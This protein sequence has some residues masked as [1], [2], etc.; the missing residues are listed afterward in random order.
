MFSPLRSPRKVQRQENIISY[1]PPNKVNS[2]MLPSDHPFAGNKLNGHNTNRENARS[3]PRKPVD[4]YEDEVKRPSMHKKTKSSVSLKSLIGNDKSKNERQ[5]DQGAEDRPSL[6]KTKSSTGL[7]AL[8]SRPKALKTGKSEAKSPAKDKENQTPPDA[9]DVSPPP[10]WAQYSTQLP[11]EQR[12][13]TKIPLNDQSGLDTVVST[14]RPQDCS[15]SGEGNFQGDR[16]AWS[17]E[18]Q[19]KNRP[20]SELIRVDQTQ[21]PPAETH[22][23]GRK[24][25]R[26]EEPQPVSEEERT[27]L[28]PRK[29]TKFVPVVDPVYSQTRLEDPQQETCSSNGQESM[30]KVKRSS[31][32]MAA[33]AVYDGNTKNARDP[34]IANALEVNL[35]IKTIENQFEALLVDDIS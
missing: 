15:P 13:S 12:T 33:V 19:L 24:K 29:Q 22:S 16:H 6:K 30:P 9:A 34:A 28:Q 3:S 20:K 1:P 4:V 25:H 21:T 10:I 17:R 27:N 14:G 31:R 23:G 8:L 7:S 26:N 2:F 32:V 18:K 35:D 5:E 11:E